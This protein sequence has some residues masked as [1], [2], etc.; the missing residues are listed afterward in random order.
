LTQKRI[1]YW[2]RR[3]RR[4]W[5]SLQLGDLVHQ[6]D[7]G[8]IRQKRRVMRALGAVRAI[9][10]IGWR[11]IS[12]GDAIAL[13]RTGQLRHGLVFTGVGKHL[14]NV[15]VGLDIENLRPVRITPCLALMEYM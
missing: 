7:V 13:A 11:A 2:P 12:Q 3:T 9:S 10:I 5:K 1:A 14:V 6:I 8:V 4:R 15:R